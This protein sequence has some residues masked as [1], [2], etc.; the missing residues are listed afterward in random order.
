MTA[1]SK[2]L[3]LSEK[4]LVELTQT[5]NAKLAE[6]KAKCLQVYVKRYTE[7]EQAREKIRQQAQA[8]MV[9]KLQDGEYLSNYIN[10]PQASIVRPIGRN[11]WFCSD[12][13]GLRLSQEEGL[14]YDVNL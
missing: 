7:K 14:Y 4:R 2:M 1:L 9:E 12:S 6:E 3:D 11:I 8:D 5:F 10:Q 13:A